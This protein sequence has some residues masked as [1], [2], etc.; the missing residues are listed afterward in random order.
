MCG[1]AKTKM[2][3]Y[4]NRLDSFCGWIMSSN[5]ISWSDAWRAINYHDEEWFFPGL[6]SLLFS[7]TSDSNSSIM[8]GRLSNFSFWSHGIM[9]SSPLLTASM[10]SKSYLM[11]RFSA[12][13]NS[14][15]G[16]NPVFSDSCIRAFFCSPDIWKTSGS[17][18]LLLLYIVEQ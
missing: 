16:F 14:Y 2:T 18:T 8:V 15:S 5:N 6:I 10:T 11:R 13:F 4:E 17:T 1:F 12:I 3:V 7:L 9:Q